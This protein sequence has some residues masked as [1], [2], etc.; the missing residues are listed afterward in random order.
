VTFAGLKQG[1]SSCLVTQPKDKTRFAPFDVQPVPEL[2]APFE[3]EDNR[4][5]IDLSKSAKNFLPKK[6]GALDINWD[7]VV[8]TRTKK[9]RTDK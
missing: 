7:K 2:M 9:Q 5:T 3:L 8:W 4:L 1:K 6:L